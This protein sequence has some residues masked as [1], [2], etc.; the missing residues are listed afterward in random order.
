MLDHFRIET[1]AYSEACT[2]FDC[3]ADL[4]CGQDRTRTDQQSACLCDGANRVGC[5][6][7]PKGDFSAGQTARKDRFGKWHGGGVLDG[8]DGD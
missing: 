3:A 5:S 1:R 4:P 6:P 7:C 2:S 8:D